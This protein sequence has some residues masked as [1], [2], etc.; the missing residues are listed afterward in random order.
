MTQPSQEQHVPSDESKQLGALHGRSE[1]RF[2][3][4]VFYLLFRI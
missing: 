4:T 2:S 1:K 3:F